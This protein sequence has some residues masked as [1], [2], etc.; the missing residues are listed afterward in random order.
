MIAV[1]I[2]KKSHWNTFD[3]E[4]M[5]KALR[6]AKKGQYT[7]RP[8][9]M[10]GCVLVKDGEVVA[11][12][13]HRKVGEAHAEINALTQAGEQAKGSVCYVTLE[14]CAHQGRTGPCAKALV[15]AGVSKVIA[16]MAD[17]NP[18][19]SGK[20]FDILSEAGIEVEYGLL[21]QQAKRLNR[22][23]ISR[24]CR[25]RP[26]VTCKLAMSLD[27]RTALADG[28][29]Q[30]ITGAS[31]R[32]DVQK[33]RAR[34]DAI[35]TGI[36]T[37]IA[38]DPSLTVRQDASKPELEPWFA[39]AERLGFQQPTRV[40]LDRQGRA[41]KEAKKAKLFQRSGKVICF[42]E[43]ASERYLPEN[44]DV[45]DY[46]DS[47]IKLLECLATEESNQVLIE[48][49]HQIAGAFLQANLIDELV[50]YMAP[51]LMGNQAMGLFD[52][53]ISEMQN[54]PLLRLQ[55]MRQLDDDIKLTYEF[56]R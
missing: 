20:G 38:D 31:A 10:V 49:G 2:N 8:N 25:Q 53:S 17:P 16:A 28:A 18:L 52:L 47:L 44:V 43:N 42:T 13:W 55:E 23:F 21:E 4:M 3:H 54:T 41:G 27:G 30:W 14:P 36:G 9:P 6:L 32:A 34:Q 45:R 7:A 35:I 22:G 29:S 48:A 15:E 56:T 11:N 33:L 39:A 37:L 50:I 46:P 1:N 40:L 12:G 5:A 19:V 26:W 51:K 24:V